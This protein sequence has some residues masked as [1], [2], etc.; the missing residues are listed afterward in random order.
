MFLNEKRKQRLYFILGLEILILS[1]LYNFRLKYKLIG[2][3]LPFELKT[4]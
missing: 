1:L 3:Y 4:Y 2:L